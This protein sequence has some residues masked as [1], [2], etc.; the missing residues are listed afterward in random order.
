V[1]Q[2]WTQN[3]WWWWIHFDS[4]VSHKMGKYTDN[5]LWTY[6]NFFQ[7]VVMNLLQFSPWG[8]K[9]FSGDKNTIFSQYCQIYYKFKTCV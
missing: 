8:W 5:Y 1:E 4:E 2:I 9:A 7:A 3:T 6:K